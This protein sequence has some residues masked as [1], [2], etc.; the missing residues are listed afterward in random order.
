MKNGYTMTRTLTCEDCKTDITTG[1]WL[2]L[3]GRD[4]AVHL[5]N[6]REFYCGCNRPL[7]LIIRP[8][9]TMHEAIEKVITD[10]QKV[11]VAPPLSSASLSEAWRQDGKAYGIELACNTLRD[12]LD[13][14]PEEEG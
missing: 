8:A 6:E 1:Q 14:Y 4:S 9:L 7:A 5:S 12:V 2:R 3:F 11:G 13:T 10:L